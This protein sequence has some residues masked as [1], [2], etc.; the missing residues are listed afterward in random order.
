MLQLAWKY[1]DNLFSTTDTGDD[2]HLLGLVEKRITNSMNDELLKPFTKEDI[3]RAVKLMTSLKARGIDGFPAIFYQRYWHIVGLEVSSY[4]LSI[5]KGEIEMGQI[6]KTHIVLIPKVEK[7]KNLTQFWPISLCN[8]I[9][10][11]IVKVLVNHM[12]DL[13]GVCVNESQGAFIL[14]RHISDN[15]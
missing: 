13:L 3:T 11:I 5:L 6:N 7:P 9:Y 14:G 2:E 12:S 10:K 4:C 1:F 8:V 15:V